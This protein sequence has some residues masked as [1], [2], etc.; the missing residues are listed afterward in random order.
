MNAQTST[1]YTSRTSPNHAT[2]RSFYYDFRCLSNKGFAATHFL[3]SRYSMLHCHCE[4]SPLR[5]WL[6]LRHP[7][8]SLHHWWHHHRWAFVGIMAIWNVKG[9]LVDQMAK[10]Y[11]I[12]YV[13]MGE[14]WVRALGPNYEFFFCID[15]ALLHRC[16]RSTTDRCHAHVV[17]TRNTSLCKA[18]FENSCE[19]NESNIPVTSPHVLQSRTRLKKC[20]QI[21]AC[22]FGWHLLVCFRWEAPNA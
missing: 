10:S 16:N 8:A 20:I 15:H 22:V 3:R 5:L 7:L 17:C 4:V 1:N 14:Q 12:Y 13:I 11:V 9:N 18:G 2:N 21:A 6:L 19:E